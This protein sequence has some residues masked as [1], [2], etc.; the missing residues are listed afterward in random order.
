MDVLTRRRAESLVD[1]ANA[2]DDP[3]LITFERSSPDAR[4][5]LRDG[6]VSYAAGDGEVF[7]YAPPIYV[8]RP[9]RRRAVALG[10]APAAP[11][12]IRAS[13]V[14]RWL[15]LHPEERPSF[16]QLATALE[17]SEA[18]VSRTVHALVADALVAIESDP[19][20]ARLRLVRLR[21]AGRLLDA[22]ERALTP[23]RPRR[24]TWDIGARDAPAAMQ[25]LHTAAEH[26]KAPYAVSGVAGASLVRRAVEPTDVVVWIRRDDADLWAD[27]L[28]ATPARPSAGRVTAQLTPDP[29]VL[30]LASKRDGI[31]VADP[32][33]LYLDCRAAGE[34]ALEAA[35]AIRVEMQW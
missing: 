32:V 8:E 26:L 23:R 21:D 25:A 24:V 27:E 19:S 12:A 30:S 28:M 17:L 33:Q 11:F 2:S 3:L 1:E 4:A 10:G 16:R 14:P 29:F 5:L 31:Q 18:M 35:D 15:L 6:R 13:R 22:F 7:L 9:P 34:R 20:D